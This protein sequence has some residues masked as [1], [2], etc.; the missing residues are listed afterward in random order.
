MSK[1]TEAKLEQAFIE[2][3]G[4]EK[5]PHYLGNTISRADNPACANTADRFDNSKYFG[6]SALEQLNTLNST[7]DQ[8]A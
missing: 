8:R 2:L 7:A 5:F 1:F 6:G 4:N 3:L